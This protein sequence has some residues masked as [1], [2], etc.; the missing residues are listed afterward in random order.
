[1][2]QYVFGNESTDFFLVQTTNFS[3]SNKTRIIK[4]EISRYIQQ[5]SQQTLRIAELDFK[6]GHKNQDQ[7][8][9]PSR[10]YF[11]IWQ[12]QLMTELYKCTTN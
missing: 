11:S 10:I 7:Q 2:I 4:N 8:V 1:M 3:V 5:S 9:V 6:L 12:C